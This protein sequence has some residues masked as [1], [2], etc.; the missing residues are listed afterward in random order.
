M[1][2]SIPKAFFL[3]FSFVI[4]FLFSCSRQLLDIKNQTYKSYNRNNE[5]GYVVSFKLNDAAVVPKS[6]VINGIVQDI[7]KENKIGDTYQINVIAQ[8]TI[9]HN[10]QVKLDKKEN[11][12]YFEKNSN[13][14]FQPVKFKLITD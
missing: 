7:A 5:R 6:V 8:T 1:R 3:L 11:G 14:F 9:I 12:I 4:F 2:N 10:Y 13:I